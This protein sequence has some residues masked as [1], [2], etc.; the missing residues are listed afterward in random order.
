MPHASYDP[1]L[2]VNRGSDTGGIYANGTLIDRSDLRRNRWRVKDDAKPR[3]QYWTG[4]QYAPLF[5]RTDCEPLPPLSPKRQ[6]AWDGARTWVRCGEK[7]KDPLSK[8]WRFYAGEGDER[9][10]KPM[11]WTCPRIE[12]EV[13]WKA[14]ANVDRAE[15]VA[16]AA[17]LL[18]DPATVVLLERHKPAPSFEVRPSFEVFAMT[19]GGQVLLDETV[20]DLSEPGWHDTIPPGAGVPVAE[21]AARALEIGSRPVLTWD[22]DRCQTLQRNMRDLPGRS[23]FAVMPVQYLGTDAVW[24]NHASAEQ[25]VR[26]WVAAPA[27]QNRWEVVGYRG[28]FAPSRAAQELLGSAADGSSLAED[29]LTILALLS[30]VRADKHPA[31]QR[32]CPQVEG[33]DGPSCQQTDLT[34][35]GLCTLHTPTTTGAS[36]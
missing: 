4:Y 23:G 15:A 32:I 2:P 5:K 21:I 27:Y 12:D 17:W 14:Q 26:R 7:S 31:G 29:A 24:R 1:A 33:Q 36:S 6:A 3:A 16:W 30:L 18:S 25:L 8:H 34:A 11:C 28:W 35:F 9:I 20:Q 13:Q 22:T 19:V 10:G